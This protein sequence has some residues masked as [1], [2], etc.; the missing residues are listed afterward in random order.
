MGGGGARQGEEGKVPG[1]RVP[2]EGRRGDAGG[3]RIGR[4]WRGKEG[5]MPGSDGEEVL[6]QRG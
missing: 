2:D 1:R 3:R 6:S 4:Y 5:K